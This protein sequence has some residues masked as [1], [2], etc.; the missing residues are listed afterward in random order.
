M[1]TV[2][3]GSNSTRQIWLHAIHSSR[4]EENELQR[5]IFYQVLIV[6]VVYRI[7]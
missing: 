2:K 6:V 1:S 7:F 5:S 3:I 4:K